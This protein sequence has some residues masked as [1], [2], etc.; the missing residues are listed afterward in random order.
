MSV[1]E[2][3]LG[4]NAQ[5]SWDFHLKF[6]EPIME[7]VFIF[8]ILTKIHFIDALNKL[9]QKSATESL[10]ILK[11]YVFQNCKSNEEKAAYYFFVS[12]ANEFL[13]H[14]DEC[15]KTLLESSKYEPNF[16]LVYLKLAKF[17]HADAVLDFAEENYIKAI[18]CLNDRFF[19]IE[20]YNKTFSSVYSNF[21][22]CLTMMHRYTEALE[23]GK[24]GDGSM[25]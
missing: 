21:A 12:I 6:F 7:N 3:F 11:N 2:S 13:G 8:D 25:S 5:K 24:T 15:I 1:F 18:N 17:A 23:R 22:S 16:Y 10:S 4:D 14:K 19:P 20:D 9:S